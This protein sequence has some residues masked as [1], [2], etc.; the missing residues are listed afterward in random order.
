MKPDLIN[1]LPATLKP[2]AKYLKKTESGQNLA[3]QRFA[4]DTITNWAPKAALARSGADFADMSFLEFSESALVYYGPKLL[5]EGLFKKA[6]TENLECRLIDKVATRGE[7]LIN[8]KTLAESDKKKLMPVKAAIALSTLAIP[9]AEY[10][11]NYI[12]NLFTLKFF[13][14]ADFNN[15][16]NLDKTKKEDSEKQEK[17]KTSA[18]NHIKLAGALAGACVGFS[19]LLA[20]KGKDSRFLQSISEAILAPGNKIFKND[21]KKAKKFN[22]YFSIDFKEENGKLALSKGQL[23]ACVGIG[24]V[25]YFGAA[26]DRGKQNFLEVLFRYPLVT[27]YVITGSEMFEKGFKKIL[28]RNEN[29]KNVLSKDGSVAALSKL[30]EIAKELAA[31][32]GTKIE[33]EYKKL[34]KQKATIKAIPE[35]FGLIVMGFFVAASSRLFTQYRFNKEN[36]NKKP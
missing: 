20:T 22:E 25:G 9:L 3:H 29:Y 13:K 16:A 19:A 30:P 6:Y 21:P 27:F 10:S 14:Q 18:I 24:G 36:Q 2:V 4:Q 7:D 5:G 8:D 23:T 26:K 1:T 35:L 15:I 34:I 12:K 33:F 31:K 28:N 17:V 32:N 11:L